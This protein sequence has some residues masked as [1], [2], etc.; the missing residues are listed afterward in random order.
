MNIAIAIAKWLLTQEHISAATPVTV[1]VSGRTYSG[2]KYTTRHNGSEE[3]RMAAS[4]S[5][6]NA[7]HL[8]SLVAS[9]DLGSGSVPKETLSPNSDDHH[10][11]RWT[12]RR[13]RCSAHEEK[14]D[15]PG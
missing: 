2:A 4:P 7:L 1:Q 14:Q 15:E 9:C 13:Q 11:L 12:N 5:F 6:R 8:G 10:S 3:E